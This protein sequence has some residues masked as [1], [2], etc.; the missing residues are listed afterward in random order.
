[1]IITLRWESSP[2]AGSPNLTACSIVIIIIQL[3][4]Y[5]ITFLG[6]AGMAQGRKILKQAVLEFL[7]HGLR[8]VFYAQPGP[9]WRGLPTAHSAE[10]L[11]SKLVASP[12]EFYIWP[13]PEGVVRG[14]TINYGFSIDNLH[15]ISPKM[16]LMIPIRSSNQIRFY[17]DRA[18]PNCNQT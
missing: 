8:Y 9:L 3:H 17:C 7:V 11:K 2:T 1:M 18:I 13:D 16:C 12:S 6:I 15:N 10:P 5:S 4:Y 14:T